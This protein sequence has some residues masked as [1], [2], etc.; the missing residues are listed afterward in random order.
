MECGR[1]CQR[2][3][4]AWLLVGI[5]ESVELSRSVE[6]KCSAPRIGAPGWTY[7]APRTH[8]SL[9]AGTR[10]GP[11]EIV[12]PLGAGA[13]G[14]VYRARDTRLARMVAIKVLA[15]T[16]ARR[17]ARLEREARA[18][19]RVSHR[20]I[21]ALHDIGR[22]D[23]LEYLVMEYL[24]GETLARRLEGGA[25]Q[26]DEA[27]SIGIQMCEALDAAHSAGVIHRDLKPSNVMLTPGGV[28]LLDF[29]LAKLHDPEPDP[30]LPASTQSR[31]STEDGAVVGT[32]PYMA[33]EQVA[34]GHVDGRADIFA[35][36]V[37]IYEMA[38]GVR[39]FDAPTRAEVA[40]AI[41]TR[42]PPVL[43]SLCSHVP[44]AL[45]RAVQRCLAKD[46]EARW[47]TARDLASELRWI[48]G[49][50]EAGRPDRPASPHEAT[51]RRRL[52]AWAGIGSVAG[53]AVGAVVL[54]GLIASGL[55]RRTA[56]IPRFTQLTFRSGTIPAA[57][58]APDGETIIYS[59][60][61]HDQPYGLYMSR[62]GSAE[63]RA[64]GITG[65]KLLAVSTSGELALLRGGHGT[66]SFFGRGA[67]TLA[68]V[69]LAGGAPRD[70]LDQ[71]VSA[72]WVPGTDQLVVSRT[73]GHVEFPIGTRIYKS[74]SGGVRAVRVAPSG[75][76]VALLQGVQEVRVSSS[77]I[78]RAGRSRRARGAMRV[79]SRGRR[80]DRRS[81]SARTGGMRRPCC[82]PCRRQERSGSWCRPPLR[83]TSSRTC[84]TTVASS[85]RRTCASTACAA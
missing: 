2:P 38:S 11:Y 29:G 54:W 73:G 74:S 24:E 80:T 84:S 18:I 27:L 9:S 15:R 5:F 72:D 43:S 13:M 63:A 36:G 56:P 68:R 82:G 6:Y 47:Q 83:C 85:S 42:T 69:S 52:L 23:G 39:P 57:R 64:L 21:C 7:T 51:P 25:L 70:V 17:I 16:D 31:F 8:M 35:L 28:K 62:T 66:L 81:G 53:L 12:V 50:V 71:V 19:S 78:D 34:G 79:T 48:A 37:V 40:A 58:F 4:T 77:S 30:N 59:A 65:A 33:P 44:A 3:V 67:G 49:E 32:Y 61:W 75:D 20:Y 22:Q 60:A 10:I 26:L 1:K 41:L 45:D 55:V 46:P 76:R 14:D